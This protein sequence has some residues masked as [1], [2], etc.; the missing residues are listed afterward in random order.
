MQELLKQA[1]EGWQNY[2]D[3]GKYAALLIASLLFFWFY[4]E[5]C[6][7]KLLLVYTTVMT[8]CCICPVTAALLMKY[9]TGFYDYRWI[10]SYVPVSMM[11]AYTGVCLWDMVGEKQ[12]KI[13]RGILAA[14]ILV[15]V[16][17]CGNIGQPGS[18]MMKAGERAQTKRLITALEETSDGQ[19]L[20][21]WAPRDVMEAVRGTTGKIRLIY[22]RNIWD[23]ALG[24]YFYE[25][26]SETEELLYLWMCNAEETGSSTYVAEN[27]TIVE[28][29]QCIQ[30]AAEAGVNRILLPENIPAEE[31][32]KL[33]ATPNTQI[34]P[35]G[36]YQMITIQS[37][38]K[39]QSG[40]REAE[41]WSK[42]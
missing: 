3:A 29:S 40:I 8:I 9:Q 19:E 41:K 15:I 33:A 42:I 27:G 30:I 38:R 31:I 22:G 21:L 36:N 11:L 1:W 28:G 12:K 7:E 32:Q 39:A 4:R 10:W 35:L 14:A 24:A 17:L 23:A 34:H 5:Q 13:H 20:C 18:P 2:T 26:Y 6:R 37:K 25:P 16:L